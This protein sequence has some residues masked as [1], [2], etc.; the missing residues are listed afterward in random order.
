MFKLTDPPGLE[1]IS[2]CRQS[3]FHPHN[4]SDNDLYAE[5]SGSGLVTLTKSS[6]SVKD[7]RIS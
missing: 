6:F 1:Y 7:L 4:M 5:C 3:G 2:N